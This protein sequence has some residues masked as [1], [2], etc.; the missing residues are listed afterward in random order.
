MSR[1]A[2]WQYFL[3]PW[4]REE[5]TFFSSFP[6]DE[7]RRLI[8]EST[9][10]FL[11]RRV[12]RALI[13]TADFTLHRVTFYRNSFKPH[14]YV[15]L[16][17]TSSGGTLVRVTVSEARSVQAFMAVWF[18]FLAFWAAISLT[19]VLQQGAAGLTIPLFGLGMAVF[20]LL[21]N[22]VGRVMGY[23]DTDFLLRFLQDELELREPP[24][25]AVPV[26]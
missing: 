19:A 14:A 24:P 1:S 23:R 21:I 6:P 8:N 10:R 18:G 26:A 13:S 17:Q 12:G 5:Y 15:T 9:T 16:Q 3:N 11:G 25:W 20:G 2:G 22:L 4:W 7:C